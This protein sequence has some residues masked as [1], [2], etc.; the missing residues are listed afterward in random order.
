M[1]RSYPKSPID[2]ELICVRHDLANGERCNRRLYD[3]T[4]QQ[5]M[6]DYVEKIGGDSPHLFGIIV[7]LLTQGKVRVDFRYYT[8]RIEL[9]NPEDKINRSQAIELFDDYLTRQDKNE[10][11]FNRTH[12]IVVQRD[13]MP[14]TAELSQT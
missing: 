11:G 4:L 6:D 7:R 1:S 2:L 8:E 13:Q 10:D 9:K 3:I 12:R 5:K 14:A